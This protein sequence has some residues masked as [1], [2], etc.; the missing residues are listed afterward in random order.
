MSIEAPPAPYNA[1]QGNGILVFEYSQED[2]LRRAV[3]IYQRE[4]LME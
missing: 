2:F 3:Y 4:G 1:L